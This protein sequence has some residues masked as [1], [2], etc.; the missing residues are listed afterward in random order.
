M[1]LAPWA[2]APLAAALLL[3]PAPARAAPPDPDPWFGP[4]KAMHFTLSTVIAG[5]GYG[6]TAIFDDWYAFMPL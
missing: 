6:A 3:S 4:D 1:R 2:V 5:G